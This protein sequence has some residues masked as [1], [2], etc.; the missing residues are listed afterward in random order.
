[1]PAESLP[2]PTAGPSAGAP[3]PRELW[4]LLLVHFV[5][6]LGISLAIPFLWILVRDAG[7]DPVMYGIVGASYPLMQMVGAPILGRWSDRFGRKPVL[8]IS[9]FGTFAAWLIFIGA[10]Y[11][12]T[13]GLFDLGATTVT[14]ALILILGSRA[15]DGL[16][17]G[18]IAVAMAWAGDIAT[19]E[20]RT[21]I[22]GRLGMAANLG[23][24]IGPGLS[25]VL[26][27]TPIGLVLP[28]SLAAA[29]SLT[30]VVLIATMLTEPERQVDPGDAPDRWEG[31]SADQRE[32][33]AAERAGLGAVLRLPGLRLL[34]GINFGVFL[35]FNLFYVSIPVFAIDGMG[36]SVGTFGLFMST[37]SLLMIIVQGP[38][39][40]W[41][42]GRFGARR[43]MPFGFGMLGVTMLLISTGQTWIVF[44]AAATFALGN[45]LSYPSLVATISRTA[46]EAHQ[47]AAQGL[48]SSS[49]SAAAILGQLFGGGLFALLSGGI[50]WLSAGLF[51][52]LVASGLLAG[53]S[54]SPG[55]GPAA[56]APAQAG[57]RWEGEATPQDANGEQH[58]VETAPADG[59]TRHAGVSALLGG[60][61][62][63][64]EL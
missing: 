4:P 39:L 45:G 63:W 1:M 20:T 56:P 59:A 8:L 19:P 41:A 18:N 33:D 55:A 23:F 24:I 58:A 49:G 27:I 15:L 34:L 53:T 52:V 25:G 14:V 44:A 36:W 21:R 31:D 30:G 16:T 62:Q 17:G 50:Y 46:G 11:A 51:G 35:A 9:Q 60:S 5:G 26:G 42:D 54:A 7:G 38:V 32:A 10:L 57:P 61:S 47:G 12:P 22:F 28:L 64:E 13:T 29:I 48:A 3:I 2:A 37:L 6:T 43:L 40:G